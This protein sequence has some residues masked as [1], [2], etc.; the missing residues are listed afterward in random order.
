MSLEEGASAAPSDLAWPGQ[1]PETSQTLSPPPSFPAEEQS[2]R[3]TSSLRHH[4]SQQRMPYCGGL[5]AL[6]ALVFHPPCI[7]ALC[8]VT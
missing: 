5:T 2:S 1:T 4:C 3:A 7:H 8:Q 6:M